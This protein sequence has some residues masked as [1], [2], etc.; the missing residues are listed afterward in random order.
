VG[1]VSLAEALRI[2]QERS[3][4][5]IQ[6]TEKTSPPVVRLGDYGKYLYWLEKKRKSVKKQ[7]GGEVKG[8]RL[9]FAISSHDME[10]RAR[11]AEKFLKE[12][13]KIIVEMV[14]RGREKSLANVSKEKI[15]QFLEILNKFVPVKA[16]GDLK[17]GPRGFTLIVSRN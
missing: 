5:L 4:D 3:L 13:N 14:L 15:S 8:I 9:S 1:V 11:Q 16:E 10:I 6:V 2:A 7:K 17:K 12:G